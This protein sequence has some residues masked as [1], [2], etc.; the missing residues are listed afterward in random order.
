MTIRHPQLQVST[1]RMGLR[2]TV[3]DRV[4]AV[5]GRNGLRRPRLQDTRVRRRLGTPLPEGLQ[6]VMYRVVEAVVA[7]AVMLHR[8]EAVVGRRAGTTKAARPGHVFLG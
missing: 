2:S 7:E 3:P 5:V 4:P 1:I 6:A 8:V